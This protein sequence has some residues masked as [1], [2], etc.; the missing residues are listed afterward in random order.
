MTIARPV[1]FTIEE[2]ALVE[3]IK[4]GTVNPSEV[5]RGVCE[6]ADSQEVDPSVLNCLIF[7]PFDSCPS[8]LEE[9][10]EF[11]GGIVSGGHSPDSRGN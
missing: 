10:L 6:L 4:A 2:T 7:I 3:A 1:G 8:S 9:R 11:S 5:R